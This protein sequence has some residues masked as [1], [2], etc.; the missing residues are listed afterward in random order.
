MK[1]IK[2]VVGFIAATCTCLSMAGNQLDIEKITVYEDNNALYF[3]AEEQM[4]FLAGKVILPINLSAFDDFYMEKLADGSLGQPQKLE[5]VA[6]DFF[7]QQHD[8]NNYSIENADVNNDQEMD[9]LIANT[10][11]NNASMILQA[12]TNQ[13]PQAALLLK[14][15]LDLPSLENIAVTAKN[16]SLKLSIAPR[17]LAKSSD[18]ELT[19]SINDQKEIIVGATQI[20]AS[21][22]QTGSANWNIPLTLPKGPG[23]F[24]PEVELTF[25]SQ[26]G[27]GLLGKGGGLSATQSI[28]RCKTK[29]PY[30]EGINFDG[31]DQFCFSGQELIEVD[32]GIYRTEID[33]GYLFK[34]IEA[35]T[36][37]L[38]EL[39][40]YRTSPYWE[41]ETNN[42]ELYSFGKVSYNDISSIVIGK[43]SYTSIIHEVTGGTNQYFQL[44]GT[45]INPLRWMLTEKKNKFGQIISYAYEDFDSVSGAK[46]KQLSI[47]EYG[48]SKIEFFYQ[49]KNKYLPYYNEGSLFKHEMILDYITITTDD[50]FFRTYNLGYSNENDNSIS[51]FG[52]AEVPYLHFVQEHLPN[53]KA[54]EKIEFDWELESFGDIFDF[55]EVGGLLQT[56]GNS[57]FYDYNDDGVLDLYTVNANIYSRDWSF[58][59]L[60]NVNRSFSSVFSS[61]LELVPAGYSSKLNYSTNQANISVQDIDGDGEE[62]LFIHGN[63]TGWEVSTQS[64]RE[65]SSFYGIYKI[66]PE[67]I[68]L[69]SS[70]SYDYTRQNYSTLANKEYSI[71]DS[72]GWNKLIFSDLILE[73]DGE[74]K[75]A[76]TI[77]I[78]G[79]GQSEKIKY[80]KTE[81]SS[82]LDTRTYFDTNDGDDI[83]YVF[84]VNSDGLDDALVLRGAFSDIY[85]NK[86]DGSFFRKINYRFNLLITDDEVEDTLTNMPDATLIGH[87]KKYTIRPF[88]FIDINMDGVKDFVYL[89]RDGYTVEARLGVYN[90]ETAGIDYLASKIVFSQ[91]SYGYYSASVFMV[92]IDGDEKSDLVIQSDVC[93]YGGS[94]PT[95]IYYG[96]KKNKLTFNGFSDSFG[97]QTTFGYANTKDKNIY[98]PQGIYVKTDKNYNSKFI[99]AHNLT[100][101]DLVKSITTNDSKIFYQ[102]AGGFYHKQDESFSVGSSKGFTGFE[103][104]TSVKE[105]DTTLNR[106]T[107]TTSNASVTR[108]QFY[109]EFPFIGKVK[110]ISKSYYEGDTAENVIAQLPSS[111]YPGISGDDDSTILSKSK[112]GNVNAMARSLATPSEIDGAP[113]L[114]KKVYNFIEINNVYFTY[115]SKEETELFALDGQPISK[116]RISTFKDSTDIFRPKNIIETYINPVTDMVENEVTYT[117]IYQYTFDDNYST[118]FNDYNSQLVKSTKIQRF[119]ITNNYLVGDSIVDDY[120]FNYEFKNNSAV[121]VLTRKEE[122]SNHL[123]DNR[124]TEF[125][126]DDF[127]NVDLINIGSSGQSE[128]TKK[129]YFF[130]DANGINIENEL[131]YQD[132]QFISSFYYENFD[133]YGQPRT[134]KNGSTLERTDFEFDAIGREIQSTNHLTDYTINQMYLNCDGSTICDPL[135]HQFYKV[136]EDSLGLLSYEYYNEKLQVT[137]TAN[138]AFVAKGEQNTSE[139]HQVLFQYNPD[140]EL[141]Y[142]STPKLGP[143]NQVDL[144]Q[145]GTHF[146]YDVL[147]RLIH[148]SNP[149]FVNFDGEADTQ[150]L[151]VYKQ[152]KSSNKAFMILGYTYQ[153]TQMEVKYIGSELDSDA[154]E[155]LLDYQLMSDE[156]TVTYFDA[157]GQVIA[158]KDRANQYV[159]FVYDAKGQVIH[160]LP[161]NNVTHMVSTTYHRAGKVSSVNDINFDGS[162]NNMYDVFDRLIETRTPNFLYTYN[163]YDKYDN[164]KLANNGQY[165]YCYEYDYSGQRL[166]SKTVYE[167][168][169]SIPA[170]YCNTTS[171]LKKPYFKQSFTYKTNGQNGSRNVATSEEYLDIDQDGLNLIGGLTYFDYDDLH[172]LS[173]TTFRLMDEFVNK[174]IVE[175]D[176]DPYSGA[177]NY[178]QVTIGDDVD[179]NATGLFSYTPK[180]IDHF[181]NIDEILVTQLSLKNNN[182]IIDREI[183]WQ[184]TYRPENSTLGET[185]FEIKDATVEG[186]LQAFLTENWTFNYNN[187]GY[188]TKRQNH[189]NNFT[190]QYYYGKDQN[191]VEVDHLGSRLTSVVESV[192]GISGETRSEHYEYRSSG[193]MNK[194]TIKNS[195]DSEKV[196]NYASWSSY[197]HRVSTAQIEQGGGDIIYESFYVYDTELGAVQ[198]DNGPRQI[199]YIR[200]AMGQ[201]LSIKQHSEVIQEFVYADNQVLQSKNHQTGEIG[202]TTFYIAGKEFKYEGLNDDVQNDQLSITFNSIP[203]VQIVLDTE[204]NVSANYLLHDQIGTLLAVA[205]DHTIELEKGSDQY[206]FSPF[207]LKLDDYDFSSEMLF[208]GE[209]SAS[210]KIYTGH[211]YLED[212]DVIQMQGR[213]YDPLTGRFLSPDPFIQAPLNLQNYNRYS[214]VLNNPMVFVDPSGFEYRLP[215]T[216]QVLSY[217]TWNPLITNTSY[218]TAFDLN[219]RYYTPNLRERNFENLDILIVDTSGIFGWSDRKFRSFERSTQGEMFTV[220]L[221]DSD[222]QESI[223]RQKNR[224]KDIND[225]N[226]PYDNN[227]EEVDDSWISNIKFGISKGPLEATVGEDGL[228]FDFTLDPKE[229]YAPPIPTEN[230][231][232]DWEMSIPVPFIP[233]AELSGDIN[234]DKLNEKAKEMGGGSLDDRMCE[235]YKE[236]GLSC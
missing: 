54:L 73:K 140:G 213:M 61:D 200:D 167:G 112:A 92:D 158:V 68:D 232:G 83:V 105:F 13:Y 28:Y 11:N 147:G 161:Q 183:I 125:E 174:E 106:S 155:H 82:G 175:F 99:K 225:H 173:K 136:T 86:G 25:D 53:N 185:S 162:S 36:Y 87:N 19:S 129:Q 157:M 189:N 192:G 190:Q 95:T 215:N 219:E 118:K 179:A 4:I 138:H 20:N 84:D 48:N 41:V 152:Y 27:V 59:V 45:Y 14:E 133:I 156:F 74:D 148:K 97:Q 202:Q 17:K 176:Y 89:N 114:V 235:A 60:K 78:D 216:Y 42:G 16:G 154:T 160:S 146:E 123:T 128:I 43:T 33:S 201:V 165:S 62:D 32:D 104:I 141:V 47:I 184:K 210:D 51:G 214:Y 55:E 205:N 31:N 124:V 50:K 221:N 163:Y 209:A 21:V 231:D 100:N 122:P 71:M 8:L 134:I 94:N 115:L 15:Y 170:E 149:D 29:M 69:V 121:P 226:N 98:G 194:K 144:T 130:Y 109:L 38:N 131:K 108:S 217:D 132:A 195:Y 199:E 164:L 34:Y 56:G 193:F 77:D 143:L 171:N 49:A 196:I 224:R 1:I 166:K 5:H 110:E 22:T 153:S 223:K 119:E 81:T 150:G 233:G 113:S 80:S 90:K 18:P 35:Q 116:K 230:S 208:E 126:Y 75:Y 137:G 103:F 169:L 107:S 58:G 234:D 57:V 44:A 135:L 24:Q 6:S 101:V 177:V 93:C 168:A 186:G 79:D 181:G 66:T 227:V 198:Y 65:Y 151:H 3:V 37:F 63:G 142:Q 145:H 26:A 12:D 40:H 10:Q 85:I 72:G 23:D 120:S 180:S 64:T 229:H 172:R 204:R 39:P 207:G 178:A 111:F 211:E 182:E 102:Y 127:G 188:L 187:R 70:D 236:N 76:V 228:E 30:V 46:E 96:S 9:L 222:I 139:Y 218:V 203:E 117:H 7:T 206:A 220:E 212:I 52:N 159:T 191:N 67:S 91:D 197:P 88:N 2:F